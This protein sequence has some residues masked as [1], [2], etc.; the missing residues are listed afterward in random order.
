MKIILVHSQ[1]VDLGHLSCCTKDVF[2]LSKRV[3]IICISLHKRGLRSSSDML[4]VPSCLDIAIVFYRENSRLS[5]LYL[6][7]SNLHEFL[8]SLVSQWIKGTTLQKIFLPLIICF[9]EKNY[10]SF[11]YNKKHNATRLLWAAQPNISDQRILLLLEVLL[12]DFWEVFPSIE[13]KL[14]IFLTCQI[15]IFC[16]FCFLSFIVFFE[17]R[18]NFV[19]QFYGVVCITINIEPDMIC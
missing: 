13:S 8:T 1:G 15:C 7:A 6:N 5:L 11:T 3:F 14:K 18:C 17:K 9:T 2:F 19:G 16:N 4:V 12:D 10:N